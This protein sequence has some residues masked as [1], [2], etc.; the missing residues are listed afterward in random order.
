MIKG[1]IQPSRY[2]VRYINTCAVDSLLFSLYYL[3]NRF[4]VAMNNIKTNVK[5]LY[6]SLE[7]MKD[8]YVDMARI[9]MI[10]TTDDIDIYPKETN[11]I[12]ATSTFGG[13]LYYFKMLVKFDVLT[14]VTC[15]NC[16]THINKTKMLLSISMECITSDTQ[17]EITKRSE[18]NNIRD[19]ATADELIDLTNDVDSNS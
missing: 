5:S 16:K 4:P 12:D 2:N 6:E 11:V 9:Q 10:Q 17:S 19:C 1:S 13:W 15:T 3:V 14:N 8:G 7:L 18:D